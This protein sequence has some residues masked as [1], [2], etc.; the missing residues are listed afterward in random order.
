M[1]SAP[2][3]SGK[4][5]CGVFVPFFLTTSLIVFSLSFN[6]SSQERGKRRE[7]GQWQRQRKT[8]GAITCKE[9]R[10]FAAYLFLFFKSRRSL[11]SLSHSICAGIRRE[12]QEIREGE[13]GK[14]Q[15]RN[16]V[17]TWLGETRKDG[18]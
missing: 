17:M 10:S 2:F 12:R 7:E 9:V 16:V 8:R 11:L 15:R 18:V 3:V 1:W 6:L 4:N 13:E 5:S 14:W